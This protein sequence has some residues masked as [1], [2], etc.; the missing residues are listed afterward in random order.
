M[1]AHP[2]PRILI[3]RLSALGDIVHA[4]PLLAELR[5]RWPN[6]HIG[7]LVE[8]LGRS[9]I[10]GHPLIDR[11]HLVPKKEWK[12]DKL[13]ALRGPL[14]ALRAE[15]RAEHYELSIDVQGL[16]KSAIWGWQAGARRRIGFRGR[17]SRE[18]AT[19]LNNERVAPPAAARHVVE[20]NL[21]LLA[22][23]GITPG[24]VRF[25]MHVQPT[26]RLRVD[27][28]LGPDP[29]PLALVNPGASW[30]T[31]IWPP[32]RLGELARRLAERHGLR[33]GVTWGPG[34]EPLAEAVLAAAGPAA[35]RHPTHFPPGPGVHLVPRTSIPELVAL[36]ERARLFVGGDTGP[37]HIAAAFGIP[38]VSMMGPLDARRNGPYGERSRT[39]QHAIP[40]T[41]P[42][43]RNH[44]RWCDP[45]TDLRAVTVDE[46]YD[47][48]ARFI[49]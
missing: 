46:V 26:A 22:P 16:T 34:E 39:I 35:T 12:T 41:A 5:A 19:V 20:R 29:T 48:C 6:A 4:L 28:Q 7:W 40:R 9:L 36:I 38:T 45:A 13:A 25:P 30:A 8:P 27:E 17:D 1:A 14:R 31:K 3:L 15:L 24:P 21:A 2:A 43:W 23:L 33:V 44:R 42:P 10:E 18:L 32:E 37:T 49:N 47:A 11:V